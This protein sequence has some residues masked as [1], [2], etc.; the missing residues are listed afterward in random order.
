MVSPKMHQATQSPTRQLAVPAWTAK[1]AWDAD[2]HECSGF[3]RMK[4]QL[5]TQQAGSSQCL[6]VH[7][8][9]SAKSAK[10]RVPFVAFLPASSIRQLTT[11]NCRD[12]LSPQRSTVT[13]SQKGV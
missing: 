12:K 13:P 7:S 6:S 2:A 8:R 11:D 10:I 9:P 5:S 1:K 3:T 4:K